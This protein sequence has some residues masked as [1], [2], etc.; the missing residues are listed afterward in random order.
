MGRARGNSCRGEGSTGWV[1][2]LSVGNG[3]AVTGV[4][5]YSGRFIAEALLARGWEVVALG[6][7]RPSFAD[8][9]AERVDFSPPL[10]LD[11]EE[12]LVSA[13]SGCEAL[14][15]T[16]WVRFEH[17]GATFVE[18][19]ER[20]SRLFHAAAGARVR[21]IVHLSV[22]NASADSPFPYFRGKAAVEDVLR[23]TDCRYAIL[24]PTLIFGGREEVLVNNIAW[25]LRRLPLFLLPDG[26]CCRLQPVSVFDLAR[27]AADLGETDGNLV[28]DLAG[29]EIFTFADFVAQIRD[30]VGSH[31]RLVAA[32]SGFVSSCSALVGFLLRDRLLTRDELGALSD[33][34]LACETATTDSRFG[35][36]LEASASWL[37]GEYANELRRNWYPSLS[38][39]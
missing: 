4:F 6:R 34:L 15:N 7:R 9:L 25:L 11:N 33:N 37:G 2:V 5:S 3:G 14:F 19:I 28:L 23:R 38:N 26:G 20:S 18:A 27:I 10:L 31:A 36:W 30:A 1:C 21:R 13:L 12:A 35:D 24:R 22:S 32:P 17:G 16:Y 39:S 29:P 8:S